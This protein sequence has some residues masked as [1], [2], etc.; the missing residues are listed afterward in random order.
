MLKVHTKNFGD[1]AFLCLQGRIV[2]GESVNLL[3]V[4]NSQ[5]KI[6]TFVLDLA[7]VSA[8]DARGLG[9]M[10]EL[11]AYLES[12]GIALKLMN[13]NKLVGKVFEVTGLDSVFEI[14]SGVE[15]RLAASPRRP[16]SALGFASCP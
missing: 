10:L 2:R 16:A 1:V 5:T 6:R 14:T 9:L 3:N 13:V 8:V 15:F 4:V 11:R 7:K 12:N